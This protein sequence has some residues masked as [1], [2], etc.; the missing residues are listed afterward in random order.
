MRSIVLVFTLALSSGVDARDKNDIRSALLETLGVPPPSCSTAMHGVTRAVFA[1]T[2]AGTIWRVTYPSCGQRVSALVAVPRNATPSTS[3]VLAL[4][5]TSEYGSREVMG[6][7]GDERLGFG[8]RFYQA[9]FIVVA[10]DVFIAGEN[11]DQR[12]GW[13]TTEFYRDTPQWS[14]MGRMLADHQRAID[15]VKALGQAPNCIAAVGHSLGGH[16][17]LFLGALDNRVNVVVSVSG[18]ERIATDD[19]AQ[20]WARDSWFVYIPRLRPFVVQ[21]KPRH[22]PWDFDDVLMAVHPRPLMIV[23]GKDDPIWSHEELIADVAQTVAEAYQRAGIP[24]RF[25]V[26]LFEGGHEFP[27]QAQDEAIRFVRRTCHGPN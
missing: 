2:A 23:Q 20:R 1:P 13:D 10:P 11:F 7:Q 24:E 18:F 5:Q 27:V 22:L 21:P 16:N 14:A 17:A 12:R 4:H 26:I 8:R 19:D 9:G 3:V 25:R 15:A 6:L